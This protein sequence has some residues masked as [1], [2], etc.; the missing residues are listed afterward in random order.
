MTLRIQYTAIGLILVNFG[1]TY[2]GCL[3]R[4]TDSNGI[5][6]YEALA[7]GGKEAGVYYKQHEAIDALFGLNA[8]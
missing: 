6:M 5:E 8:F 1:T 7:D 2:I 3:T 4:T